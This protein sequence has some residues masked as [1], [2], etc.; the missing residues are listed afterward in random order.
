MKTMLEFI[1]GLMLGG[2]LGFFI[3]VFFAGL[4]RDDREDNNGNQK[5]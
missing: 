4:P 2:T 5:D 1:A 3:A